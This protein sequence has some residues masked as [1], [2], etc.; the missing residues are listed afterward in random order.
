M[1]TQTVVFNGTYTVISPTGDHRTFQIK[2]QKE[3]SRF[4]PGKRVVSILNGPNN[5]ADYLGFGFVE[6][7]GINVWSARKSNRPTYPS[8]WEQYAKMLWSLITEGEQSRFYVKGARIEVSK[9]CLICNRKLTHPA[10]LEKGIGPECDG[11]V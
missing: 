6:D 3:T 2:T 11:R 8:L 1:E 9:R 7:G 5:E 4:C 10:S